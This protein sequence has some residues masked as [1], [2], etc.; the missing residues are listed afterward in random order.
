VTD[1]LAIARALREV[2]TLLQIKGENPFKV[3][4]YDA[5]SPAA[6]Q[7]LRYGVGLARRGWV[8]RG[9]VLNTLSAEAFVEAVRPVWSMVDGLSTMDH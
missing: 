8:R 7:H 4:A 5:H 9:E 2:G 1:K 6:L 3:R